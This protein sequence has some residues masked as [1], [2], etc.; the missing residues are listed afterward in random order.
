MS[1]VP[2]SVLRRYRSLAL[3]GNALRAEETVNNSNAPVTVVGGGSGFIG[4]HVGRVL[5]ERGFRVVVLSGSTGKDRMT[6][7]ELSAKGLPKGTKAGVMVPPSLAALR[8]FLNCFVFAAMAALD[9]LRTSG[10]LR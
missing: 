7:D 8:V 6:W 3:A 5:E 10:T 1:D 4:Q 2:G 9:R